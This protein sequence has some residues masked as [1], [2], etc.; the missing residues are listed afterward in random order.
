MSPPGQINRPQL[1]LAG[2]DIL[3][4]RLLSEW[5]D[6]SYTVVKIYRLPSACK[7]AC[8]QIVPVTLACEIYEAELAFTLI[9]TAVIIA[10]TGR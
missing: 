10:Y 8:L 2:R 9:H 5:V 3:G 4:S 1:L 7:L 6:D